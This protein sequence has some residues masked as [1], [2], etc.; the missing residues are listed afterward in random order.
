MK[1]TLEQ[2]PQRFSEE[3][4]GDLHT[5][6]S[7]AAF[8]IT[9]SGS[10]NDHRMEVFIQGIA[11]EERLPPPQALSLRRVDNEWKLEW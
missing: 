6:G 10:L 9:F 8:R 2:H 1:T 4:L 3:S 7:F 11:D 5:L